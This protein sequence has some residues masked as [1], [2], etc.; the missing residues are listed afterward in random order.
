LATG[1]DALLAEASWVDRPDNPRGVHMSGTDAGKAA[2]VAGVGRLLIT[3]VPPWTDS[4]QVLAEAR[5]AFNGPTE[6]VR[7]GAN[8]EI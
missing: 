4:E 7:P 1:A 5:A 3:H 2:A 8:Y 6:L